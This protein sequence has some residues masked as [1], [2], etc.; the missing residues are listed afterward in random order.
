MTRSSAVWATDVEAND[1]GDDKPTSSRASIILPF[2]DARDDE[3]EDFFD[4]EAEAGWY[5]PVSIFDANYLRDLKLIYLLYDA[6]L[7]R[8]LHYFPQHSRR[9]TLMKGCET[10]RYIFETTV[11]TED[12]KGNQSVMKK[13]FSCTQLL[14]SEVGATIC[15]CIAKTPCLCASKKLSDINISEA[16]MEYVQITHVPILWNNIKIY[17]MFSRT[18]H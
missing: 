3:A 2:D 17:R 11:M 12:E 18:T 14:P 4:A 16:D 15:D 9:N 5:V 8:S 10:K 7:S 1:L 13:P 6:T